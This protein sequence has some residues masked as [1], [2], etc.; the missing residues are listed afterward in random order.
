MKKILIYL[1][2]AIILIGGLYYFLGEQ[3]LLGGLLGTAGVGAALKKKG[4]ELD[5]KAEE[6]KEELE[7]I[8][9]DKE[10]LEKDGVKDMTPEEETEYWKNQ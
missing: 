9:K 6:K 3:G 8:K 4:A 2:L 5:A 1:V 7:A 10:K